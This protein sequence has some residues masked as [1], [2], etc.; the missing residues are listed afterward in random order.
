MSTKRKLKYVF[1]FT[2]LIFERVYYFFSGAEC[3]DVLKTQGESSARLL[4]HQKF[5]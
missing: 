2:D 4:Y 3:V 1:I 5:H